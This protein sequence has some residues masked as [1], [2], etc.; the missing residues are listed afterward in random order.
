MHLPQNNFPQMDNPSIVS[1]SFPQDLD[2]SWKQ[3]FPACSP[4]PRR[5]G[6]PRFQSSLAG[7]GRIQRTALTTGR[8]WREERRPPGAQHP[9]QQQHKEKLRLKIL[10]QMQHV[11]LLRQNTASSHYKLFTNYSPTSIHLREAKIKS[12]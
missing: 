11:D 8:A 2:C 10:K 5:R 1:G 4:R 12:Q 6:R 7:R 3:E 9:Q